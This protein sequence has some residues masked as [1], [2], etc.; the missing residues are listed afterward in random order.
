MKC[1]YCGMP[2]AENARICP[3]C[4]H[5][6]GMS[7]GAYTIVRPLLLLGIGAGF[8]LALWLVI[9]HFLPPGL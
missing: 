4:R 6:P 7:L 8:L 5:I 2:I 1:P 3:H 9:N